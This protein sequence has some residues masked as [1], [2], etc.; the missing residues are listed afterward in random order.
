MPQVG[1]TYK[2]INLRIKN[3]PWYIP[4]PSFIYINP[5]QIAETWSTFYSQ[6]INKLSESVVYNRPN[7]IPLSI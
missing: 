5:T 2:R 6:K 4:K 3:D 1:P 7:E